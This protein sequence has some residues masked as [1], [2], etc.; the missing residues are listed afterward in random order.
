MTDSPEAE[1]VPAQQARRQLDWGN[2]PQW[3]SAVCAAIVALV[4]IYALFFSA[5]SQMLVAYLHS[6]LALRNSKIASLEAQEQQLRLLISKREIELGTIEQRLATALVKEK[7][8]TRIAGTMVVTWPL[9]LVDE[10]YS[11]QGTRPRKEHLWIAYLNFIRRVIEELPSN[12]QALGQEV[13][14]KLNEQCAH[15]SNIVIDVPSS[16][17]SDSDAKQW[18]DALQKKISDTQSEIRQCSR[19]LQI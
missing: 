16:K 1:D 7:I 11:P 8:S 17:T 15:L 5:T 13:L 18:F 2:V 6:E 10:F 12:E 19:D 4:A 3:V 14:R 9:R